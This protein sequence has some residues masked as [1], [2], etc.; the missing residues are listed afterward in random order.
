MEGVNDLVDLVLKIECNAFEGGIFPLAACF[1]HS[2]RANV[3]VALQQRDRAGLPR[4]GEEVYEARALTDVAAGEELCINYLGLVAQ[5]RGRWERQAQLQRG[6]RGFVCSCAA[7]AGADAGAGT[8]RC[9]HGECGEAGGMGTASTPPMEWMAA[10]AEG[11]KR[12]TDDGCWCVQTALDC[13]SPCERCSSAGRTTCRPA[14]SAAEL[15]ACERALR[16]SP[17]AEE[18]R[19]P[20]WGLGKAIK[21]V[22]DATHPWHWL[23]FTAWEALAERSQAAALIQHAGAEEDEAR[24]A[25]LAAHVA[26]SR[27]AL[28]WATAAQ[29]YAPHE[30]GA[31][32]LQ[33]RLAAALRA[34]VNALTHADADRGGG[35]QSSDDRRINVEREELEALEARARASMALV[36]GG[37]Q[38][39]DLW[40]STW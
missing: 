20:Y 2:C 7:C 1:N 32:R 37:M 4:G 23:R 31:C 27:G 17:S 24:C 34:H 29:C 22:V 12:S 38:F 26:A 8:L 21:L 18:L 5:H 13:W 33:E 15:T 36:Y 11:E 9:A 25:A 28:V 14:A 40:Q 16:A 19:A 3:A 39:D 10:L 6:P 35:G 30:R